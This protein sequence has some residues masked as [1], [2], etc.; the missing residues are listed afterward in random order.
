MPTAAAPTPQ[1]S[2]LFDLKLVSDAEPAR[3]PGVMDVVTIRPVARPMP[4]APVSLPGLRGG[5]AAAGATE[6][7]PYA[8]YAP[9]WVAFPP[10]III[11]AQLGYAW[12]LQLD[13]DGFRSVFRDRS[14]LIKF[15]LQRSNSK[16]VILSVCREALES[17]APLRLSDAARIFDELNAIY[18]ANTL[19][20]HVRVAVPARVLRCAPHTDRPLGLGGA[21][22]AHLGRTCCPVQAWSRP[23]STRPIVAA[24]RAHWI[25]AARWS[26]RP[27]CFRGSSV[28]SR[29]AGCARPERRLLGRWF[30]AH[31]PA[32]AVRRCGKTGERPI[33]PKYLVAVLTEYIRSLHSYRI[34]V[35]S[36]CYELVRA[37]IRA[38]LHC[39]RRPCLTDGRTCRSSSC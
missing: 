13:L 26:I 20:R 2:V 15:L 32:S 18:S 21:R 23:T 17:D 24:L 34:T 33:S 7:A 19:A 39:V 30:R 10:N 8:L 4:I 38:A 6:T 9:R 27:I 25:E 28:T 37:C 14:R 31:S 12:L 22:P 35:Q 5:S 36:M 1:T 29:K 3:M 11:D 16:Q